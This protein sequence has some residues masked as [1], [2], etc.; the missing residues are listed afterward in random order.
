MNN[1]DSIV[2]ALALALALSVPAV[3]A[4]GDRSA[5]TVVSIQDE[6]L[7][8]ELG[9]EP[10]V[11]EGSV[12]KVWRRLPSARGSAEYRTSSLW[13][14]IAEV[15]VLQVGDGVAV[16][17]R[18]GD[19]VRPMPSALDETGAPGEQV[20]IGDRVRTTGAVGERSVGV[21]VTFPREEL[22]GEADV[23]FPEAGAKV[24]KHWLRGLRSME[25]PITIE[26]HAR[27]DEL[28][29]EPPDLG[30]SMSADDDA[31]FGAAPG[32]PV[33]PVEG[34]EESLAVP[35]EPPPAH[36]VLVVDGVRRD[37]QPEIWRYLDPVTLAR[38]RG[39]RVA[40]AIA[41]HL[42]IPMELVRISVVPRGHSAS[43]PHAVGYDRPGDQVR[44][45]AGGIDWVDPGPAPKPKPVAPPADTEEDRDDGK[46]RRRLLERVPREVSLA[47]SSDGA[48]GKE[49]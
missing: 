25:L 4:A 17:R 24:M 23:E 49:R 45:L 38:R 34:L 9:A 36:E 10:A 7:V 20:H 31:P 37:G 39:E 47:P 42:E 30:R 43:F 3:A 8:I 48:K 14:E 15:T 29:G 26:V 6:I 12:L 18:T 28:N 32:D 16:A 40:A 5:G 19:P 44:I 27:L 35:V 1:I 22:F 46:H 21:R 13:W 2:P 11:A 33:V 41:T